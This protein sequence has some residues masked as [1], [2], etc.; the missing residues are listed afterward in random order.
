MTSTSCITS[1]HAKSTQKIR[2]NAAEDNRLHVAY[3]GTDD[4]DTDAEDGEAKET[5]NLDK[6][7]KGKALTIDGLKL[8]MED[9]ARRYEE[10]RGRIIYN[11]VSIL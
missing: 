10:A 11:A 5:N 4:T 6:E 2:P 7:Y 9:T 1:C 3:Y 8:A